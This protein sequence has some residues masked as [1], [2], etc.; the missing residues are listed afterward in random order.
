[1]A[2]W[3]DT[4]GVAAGLCSMASFVPQIVKLAREKEAEGVSFRTFAITS[5]GFVLW[6]S[7]G[8]LLKSWPIAA[9]NAVCL[10]LAATIVIL[11]WRYGDHSRAPARR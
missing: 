5:I 11:T 10:A 2:F 7:Y 6:T 3:I 1:M 8:V 9:A 4:I